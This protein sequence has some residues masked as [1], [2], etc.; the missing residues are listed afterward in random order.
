MTGSDRL[1]RHDEP[2]P[3]LLSAAITLRA[4]DGSRLGDSGPITS[5]TVLEH[6]PA[7]E[8]IAT[9]EGWFRGHGFDVDSTFANSFSI[10]GPPTTF[11]SVFGTSDDAALILPLD[12]LPDEIGSLIDT[13]SFTQVEVG[14]DDF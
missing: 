5:A 12:R 14:P 9:T 1:I 8:A 4:A 7:P 6:A 2:M 10:T 13:I 3:G 11:D